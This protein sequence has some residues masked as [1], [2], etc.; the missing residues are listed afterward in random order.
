[1]GTGSARW[2]R[3]STKMRRG[4][5]LGRSAAPRR[6][7]KSSNSTRPPALTCTWRHPLAD[8]LL[9]FSNAATRDLLRDLRGAIPDAFRQRFQLA[10]DQY[11]ESKRETLNKWDTLSKDMLKSQDDFEAGKE[12]GFWGKIWYNLGSAKD[13]IDPWIALIPNEY[14][15]AAVKMGVAVLLKVCSTPP[16][17]ILRGACLSGILGAPAS[18]DED[19]VAVRRKLQKEK[20]QHS[21][22]VYETTGYHHELSSFQ[23]RVQRRPAGQ[24]ACRQAISC[25]RRLHQRH[26]SID[27]SEEAGV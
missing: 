14:G 24:R 22:D 3:T 6:T 10:L 20:G 16:N 12:G 1:M 2:S 26:A 23:D 4:T 17:E 13:A 8:H 15:L 27:G 9:L 18:A 11:D 5:I 25:R 7:I 21:Y 19:L